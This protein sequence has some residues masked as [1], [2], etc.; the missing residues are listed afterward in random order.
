M[1]CTCIT[2]TDGKRE[3]QYGVQ[4]LA[5][6]RGIDTYS[7]RNFSEEEIQKIREAKTDEVQRIL[8]LY[9]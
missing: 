3:I 2:Y 1:E 7:F 5:N 6:S 8:S 9:F 4:H